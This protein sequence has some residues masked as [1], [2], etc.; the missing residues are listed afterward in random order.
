LVLSILVVSRLDNDLHTTNECLGQLKTT[1][2][3]TSVTLMEMK[4]AKTT[5]NATLTNIMTQLAALS[6][7]IA[8]VV[9]NQ[10]AHDTIDGHDDDNYSN[11]A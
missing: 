7:Y 10:P 8:N 4:T 11:K 5:T 1:P 3:E 6:Q 2:I 9:Q